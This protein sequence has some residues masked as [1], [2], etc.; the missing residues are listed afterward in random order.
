MNA[1]WPGLLGPPVRSRGEET[2]CVRDG[3]VVQSVRIVNDG[4][5][6]AELDLGFEGNI[7]VH[8]A[9]YTQ[10]TPQG[11]CTLPAV[12]L[13]ASE[14]ASGAWRL[15]NKTLPAYLDIS[16]AVDGRM[17]PISSKQDGS[18]YAATG[19]QNIK[20]G[21]QQTVVIELHFSCS[22]STDHDTLFVLS[23]HDTCP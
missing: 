20:F 13:E 4:T 18:L 16:L 22:Q 21:A 12:D 1:S 23:E 9:A 11:D 2:F 14:D 8:R 7:S 3:V 6:A 19:Q 5:D 17:V 10:L 15:V